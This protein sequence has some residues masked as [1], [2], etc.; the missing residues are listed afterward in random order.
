MRRE[1]RVPGVAAAA[2][3][4]PAL[5]AIRPVRG[6]SFARGDTRRGEAIAQGRRRAGS[7]PRFRPTGLTPGSGQSLHRA[8]KPAAASATACP[9]AAGNKGEL[10]CAMGKCAKHGYSHKC[11]TIY[12][13]KIVNLITN[14]RNTRSKAHPIAKPKQTITS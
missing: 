13:L 9:R 2:P 10:M 5:P 14:Q 8:A 12:F 6:S 1:P 3:S 7:E 4:R 11:L